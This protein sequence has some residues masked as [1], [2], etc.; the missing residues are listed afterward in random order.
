[1]AG[2][3]GRILPYIPE[4]CTHNAHMYYIKCKNLDE[5][6]RF[7]EFMKGKEIMTVFHYVP[8][9]SA[10]AGLK[11]GRFDGED[12]YTTIESDKLVRLPMYYHLQRRDRDYIIECVKE[13][14]A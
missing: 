7:I 10:P 9:H 12:V 1:M 8:L 5:R 6:T 3:V 2:V 14:Y 11:Y 4:E 13:F